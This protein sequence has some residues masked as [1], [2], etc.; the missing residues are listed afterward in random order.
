MKKV[1]GSR[2]HG[3]ETP[4]S[5]WDIR[6]VRVSSLRTMLSPFGASD[7][8]S[9]KNEAGDVE[10][11]ELKKFCKLLTSGNPTVW[12]ILYSNVYPESYLGWVTNPFE[13]DLWNMRH[14]FMDTQHILAAHIGYADSQLKRYFDRPARDATRLT[15][16]TWMKR[17]PKAHV[18]A[19]RVLDQAKQLLLTGDFNPRVQEPLRSRLFDI[20]TDHSDFLYDPADYCANAASEIK[21][22]IAVLKGYTTKIR[23]CD[24]N[25]I[26]NFIEVEY[27]R[28][29]NDD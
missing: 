28:S 15:E 26:M 2:L 21:D 27:T 20:K 16:P 17:V 13:H 12:E 8:H 23:Q 24:F 14:A 11:F 1:V 22:E 19:L 4:T 7:P 3:L 29:N 6:E 9:E 10:V 5:D 25:R 18:A